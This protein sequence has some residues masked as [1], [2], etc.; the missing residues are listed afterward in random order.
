M[1]ERI[2]K[3][4]KV[5]IMRYVLLN[6][7]SIDTVRSGGI[8][9]IPT[10]EISRSVEVAALDASQAIRK[11]KYSLTQ[12]GQALTPF[13]FIDEITRLGIIEVK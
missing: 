12:K 1:N 4:Y 13:E 11:V 5:T 2:K 9:Q 8:V 7:E 3:L 6:Q 10:F